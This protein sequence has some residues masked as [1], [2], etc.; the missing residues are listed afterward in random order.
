METIKTNYQKNQLSPILMGTLHSNPIKIGNNPQL[1]ALLAQHIAT[2]MEIGDFEHDSDWDPYLTIKFNNRDLIE[3]ENG[4]PQIIFGDFN[5]VEQDTALN[6][7]TEITSIGF[8]IPTKD[9]MPK[10]TFYPLST[11]TSIQIMEP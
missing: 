6:R 8:Y 11:I 2:I 1:I 10:L 9:P 4:Y 3:T 5:E 7:Y